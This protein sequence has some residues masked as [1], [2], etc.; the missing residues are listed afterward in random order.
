MRKQ[1]TKRAATAR[2]QRTSFPWD[3]V[4]G[5]SVTSRVDGS[6][7]VEPDYINPYKGPEEGGG[8]GIMTRMALADWILNRLTKRR[9]SQPGQEP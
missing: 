9:T 7:L 8:P 4:K 1:P 6:M 5:W 2:P 3:V